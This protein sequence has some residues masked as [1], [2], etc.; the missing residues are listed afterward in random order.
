MLKKEKSFYSKRNGSIAGERGVAWQQG[1][2]S[3][4]FRHCKV[5][6]CV[7]WGTD[8]EMEWSTSGFGGNKSG[9]VT[10]VKKKGRREQGW[11]RKAFRIRQGK[12]SNW[13]AI[14]S[15]EPAGGHS[16][17]DKVSSQPTEELWSKDDWLEESLLG[18]SGQALVPLPHSV[19]GWG[20]PRK[21]TAS[22]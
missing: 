19:I 6:S 1:R 17:H 8:D 14:L 11:A 10:P 15:A 20:L 4:F 22:P 9:A 3:N 21:S 16:D 5:V 13:D 12:P 7:L 18:R 2:D